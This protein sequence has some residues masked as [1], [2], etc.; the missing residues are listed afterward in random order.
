MLDDDFFIEIIINDTKEEDIITLFNDNDD[1]SAI[2][3]V[4]INSKLQQV[5]N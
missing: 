3:I 4:N 2:V 1:I 5:I